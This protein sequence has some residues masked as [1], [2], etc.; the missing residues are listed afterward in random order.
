[1]AHQHRRVK[2]ERFAW[3]YSGAYEVQQGVML[4]GKGRNMLFIELYSCR[5]DVSIL[6]LSSITLHYSLYFLPV[7]L[8]KAT[9]L[10][11][12]LLHDLHII[13]VYFCPSLFP[14]PILSPELQSFLTLSC[15]HF[16]CVQPHLSL[17]LS[18]SISPSRSFN[19]SVFCWRLLLPA[20]LWKCQKGPLH[21]QLRK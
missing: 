14:L 20:G 18:P 21:F 9:I 10:L 3:F 7:N 4:L 12:H 2:A 16:P 11:S 6:L 5:L 15:N 17:C 19:R 8:C 1:M 13:F